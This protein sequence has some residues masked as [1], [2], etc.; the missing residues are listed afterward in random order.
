MLGDIKALIKEV[1]EEEE[2]KKQMEVAAVQSKLDLLQSQINPHF[3]HNT[4]N[5]ISYLAMKQGAYD[6]KDI[7]QSFNLLLRASMHI[8]KKFITINEEL[9]CVI[10]YLKIQ[11]YR[12]DNILKFTYDLLKELEFCKIPR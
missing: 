9:S 8:D 3:V 5:T 6:I 4:L 12:Y 7:I 10:S 2:L 1:H 11:N